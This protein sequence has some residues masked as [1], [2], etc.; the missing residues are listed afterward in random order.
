VKVIKRGRKA[1]GAKKIQEPNRARK[2]DLN[3]V[4]GGGWGRQKVRVLRHCV[5]EGKGSR[6]KK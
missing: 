3:G 6:E 1:N 4:K 2:K 5:F